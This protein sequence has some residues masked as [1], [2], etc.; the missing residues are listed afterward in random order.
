MLQE[1]LILTKDGIG[2]RFCS[3]HAVFLVGISL[4]V[5]FAGEGAGL[6][7]TPKNQSNGNHSKGDKWVFSLGKILHIAPSHSFPC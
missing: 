3:T 7:I 4:S 6:S 2:E 5:Y 1:D